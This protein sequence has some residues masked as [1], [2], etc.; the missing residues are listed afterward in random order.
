MNQYLINL[1]L[2]KDDKKDFALR[3]A[4]EDNAAGKFE[5]KKVERDGLSVQQAV[6]R[7]PF[8]NRLADDADRKKVIDVFVT[9]LREATA[10]IYT[11]AAKYA[12]ENDLP[13]ETIYVP[14]DAYLDTMLHQINATLESILGG[15]EYSECLNPEETEI[16]EATGE[17]GEHWVELCVFYAVNIL[18][19]PAKPDEK[20]TSVDVFYVFCPYVRGDVDGEPGYVVDGKPFNLFEKYEL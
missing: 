18:D 20:C 4:Q 12:G 2:G 8:T 11:K 7:I 17:M 5:I 6:V 16:D 13:G 15:G 19:H 10:L 9:Y 1:L 14:S 3:Y